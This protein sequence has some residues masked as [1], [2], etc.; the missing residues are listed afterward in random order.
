M[1]QERLA[2][3]SGIVLKQIIDIT[4]PIILLARAGTLA[5]LHLSCI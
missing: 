5:V 3:K 2:P 1:P 4:D